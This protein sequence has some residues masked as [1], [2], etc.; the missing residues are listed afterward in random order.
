MVKS[1][2][3]SYLYGYKFPNQKF[4]P[5]ELFEKPTNKGYQNEG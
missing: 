4:A 1:L 2:H 5:L 3:I